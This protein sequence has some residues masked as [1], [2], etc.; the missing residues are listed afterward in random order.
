[1]LILVISDNH[2]VMNRMIDVVRRVKPD[3][4]VHLGDSQMHPDTLRELVGCPVEAVAGNCDYSSGLPREKEIL[5][6]GIRAFL[7]HGDRYGVRSG[8]G[9]LRNA[10]ETRGCQL[11]L[12]GHTH[13]PLLEHHPGMVVLNP[14]SISAPRQGDGAGT[15]A[16]IEIDDGGQLHY[17]LCKYMQPGR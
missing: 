5:L 2:G 9:Y 7:T 6:G 14:G 13:V 10:A 1:M 4:L 15:Y 3:L 12:Y 11:A 17:T 8:T 16:L